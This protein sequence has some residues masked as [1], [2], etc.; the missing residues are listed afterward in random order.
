M[1]GI[2]RWSMLCALHPRSLQVRITHPPT[3]QSLLALLPNSNIF[4][5]LLGS[6]PYV[7]MDTNSGISPTVVV[8]G[9]YVLACARH[10]TL[11]HH[12]Y[13][14]A[15]WSMEIVIFGYLYRCYPRGVLF[16]DSSTTILKGIITWMV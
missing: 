14:L 16:T 4:T 9:F 6:F 10:T 13:I 8:L 1:L 2:L 12:A 5:Q 3:N 11:S 7:R 15:E